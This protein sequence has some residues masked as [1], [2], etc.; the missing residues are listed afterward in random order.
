MFHDSYHAAIRHLKHGSWYIDAHMDS[1]QAHLLPYCRTSSPA[2]PFLP[3]NPLLPPPLTVDCSAWLPAAGCN[4][5][6]LWH[7]R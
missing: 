4:P 7:R 1:A 3:P 6:S 2:Q 5:L